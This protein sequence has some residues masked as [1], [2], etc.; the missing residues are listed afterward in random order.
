MAAKGGDM[1]RY[2]GRDWTRAELLSWVAD[3]S[4]IAGARPSVLSG[5]KAEGVGCVEVSTGS[6]L[7]FTVLPGR[8]MDI[9]SASYKGHSIGFHTGTGIASPAYFEEPGIGFLRNFFGGLLTTCGITNAGSPSVDQGVP[10]GIHG[11]MSNT[12]AEDLGIEHEWVG[13]EYEIRIRGTLRES[14]FFAENLALTRRFTTRLGS[15]GFRMSDTVENRGFQSQPFMLLYHFNF[16]FPLLGPR[17]RV[18]GPIRES[19]PRDEEARKDRGVEECLQ[20]PAPV[21][22]Y[23]EKVFFHTL[24]ADPRGRTFIALV[25][26]DIGDGT[27]LGI[28]MRWSLAELPEFTQ[29]K[30]PAQGAYVL[31][32]EPGTI[33]PIGRGPLREKGRLPMIEPLESRTISI[34]FEVLDGAEAMDAVESEARSL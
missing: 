34:D 25:N 32:L 30:N 9:P 10:Y 14:R 29:W 20:I 13:N 27:A 23:K 19:V 33:T 31:G 24:G 6:G 4:Q 15:R 1:A 3:L 21:P 18:V 2:A 16:G 5:G 28:V 7:A 11:R 8:G 17:A 26:R 12:G 22:G